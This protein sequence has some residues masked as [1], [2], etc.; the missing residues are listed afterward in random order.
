[1]DIK[2]NSNN[3]M[4]TS[5]EIAYL[6]AVYTLNCLAKYTTPYIIEKCKDDDIRSVFQFSLDLINTVLEGIKSIFN[7]VKMP[8]PYGFNE[9]DVN[10][11]GDNLFSD[12]LWLNLLKTRTSTGRTSYGNALPLA[13]RSDVKQFIT[14]C[15]ISTIELSNKID[16]IELNKGIFTRTPYMR[17]PKS[18][19]FA[20]DKSI[21][22]SVIGHKRILNCMEITHVFNIS[23]ISSV[24]E[25][26]L[27]GYSQ[28]IKNN[29]I[30]DYMT[31]GR[32]LLKK[33]AEALNVILVN[34]ELSIPQTYE[35]EVLNA[36]IAPVTDRGFLIWSSV[37]LL[38]I[39][40]AYDVGKISSMR[41]DIFL[42]F[43]Q[44]STEVVSYLKEGTDIMIENGWFE[45]QP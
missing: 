38:N 15:L 16:E 35:T 7:S 4:L 3:I 43:A 9:K 29:I 34:E 41:K 32:K 44:L 5:S 22:G 27:T 31:K 21:Y 30:K 23:S 6:W 17:I 36:T 20:H 42:K 14:N 13:A 33:H 18:I 25:A 19:G 8:I 26:H 28:V 24:G 10:I 37:M 45:E 39:I 40:N 12:V 2:H 1:M 11:Q